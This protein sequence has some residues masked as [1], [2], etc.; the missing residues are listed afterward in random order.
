MNEPISP[1]A[2]TRQSWRC[3]PPSSMDPI[4]Y[5]ATFSR[6]QYASIRR[7]LVPDEMEDKW[8]IFWE[9]DILYL[10][11]SWTGHCIYQ[12]TFQRAHHGYEVSQ[13]LVAADPRIYNRPADGY[14]VHLLDFLIHG[15]LL[16]EGV[17]FPVPAGIARWPDRGLYQ[18]HIAGAAFP[19]ERVGE[20][21][22]TVI[23][24][25]STLRRWLRGGSR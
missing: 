9:D 8:F 5:H 6:T 13:A 21:R 2:A 10:H 22:R 16:H 15:L 11:R 20:N 12:V 14:D 1:D 23:R 4:P 19:E 25:W 7:G 17:K 18:H 24:A 3:L